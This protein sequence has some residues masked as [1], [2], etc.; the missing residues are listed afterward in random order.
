MLRLALAVALGVLLS[1]CA[2]RGPLS[3]HCPQF[4]SYVS[5]LP[6]PQV[7]RDIQADRTEASLAAS[8]A[9]QAA[10]T[11]DALDRSIDRLMAPRDP[12]APPGEQRVR[13]HV[14]LLSGGGQ[15]GAFGTAFL[16]SL[17]DQGRLPE[18]GTITGVSTGGL[19][20]LFVGVGDSAAFDELARAYS[21]TSEKQIVDRNAQWM[22]V[23][24]G[25]IA[26]LKPLRRRIEA[27]LCV[28]GDPRLGCPNI[29]RLAASGR[30]VF[31][32][33]IEADD[34][35]FHYADAVRIAKSAGTGTAAEGLAARRDAQQCLVGAALASAAM[36][37]FFQQIRVGDARRPE[38]FKAYYDG[39]VRQSVFEVEIARR[40]ERGMARDAQRPQRVDRPRR[41]PPTLYVVR[42][43]PTWVPDNAGPDTKADALTNA[44]RAEAIVT[45]ELEVNSIASLR[46]SHPTG[47]I[48]LVTA[49]RFDHMHLAPPEIPG[50][51]PVMQRC[52]KPKD[53]MFDP[54]FM[55]CLRG[56]GRS[57]AARAPGAEWIALSELRV[58]RAAATSEE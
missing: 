24:T 31:I 30:N 49:D 3:I 44:L 17:H 58:P 55:A 21:P 54:G 52:E 15:W 28:N 45:N 41:A 33:F 8:A 43:G 40:L 7:I 29:E 42:N 46:L 19:Q 34:G 26:G 1:G 16:K 14:L 10:E 50:Q 27:A 25:S 51:P 38:S 4:G 6:P 37:V 32:G 57:K 36:P 48:R 9:A 5:E 13:Q 11:G 47:P 22:A 20:A 23:A 53:V 56:F 35:N 12:A 2:T 18:F 39:G